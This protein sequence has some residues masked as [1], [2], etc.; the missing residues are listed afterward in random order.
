L[1]FQNSRYITAKEVNQA[2]RCSYGAVKPA[3]ARLSPSLGFG[4]RTPKGHERGERERQL[5]VKEAGGG[6]RVNVGNAA[7]AQAQETRLA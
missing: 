1:R 4:G 2:V 6:A 3:A 5:V 7:G